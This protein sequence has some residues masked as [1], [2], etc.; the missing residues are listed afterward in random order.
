LRAFYAIAIFT[1]FV[2]TPPGLEPGTCGLEVRRSI[3]LSYGRS[4]DI[5]YD[6][7]FA[8]TPAR[9]TSAS[10]AISSPLATAPPPV[11]GV[12]PFVRLSGPAVS[13]GAG[14]GVRGGVGVRV[15]DGFAV[16]VSASDGSGVSVA[17]AAPAVRRVLAVGDA[18]AVAVGD[19]VGPTA[20]EGGS[21]G[22]GWTK[23]GI[24]IG[25]SPD[26]L[27]SSITATTAIA[28]ATTSASQGSKRSK[29]HPSEP[30]LHR[31]HSTGRGALSQGCGHRTRQSG[32]GESNPHSQLGRLELCH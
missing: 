4:L 21:V 2:A 24:A 17:A 1:L 25:S 12:D 18:P 30:G 20:V 5:E 28:A 29:T 10:P 15:G 16:G 19:S 26:R 8:C 13:A 31:C 7:P 27:S 6:R 3:Q 32:R 22:E 11:R 14:V 9:S 23:V